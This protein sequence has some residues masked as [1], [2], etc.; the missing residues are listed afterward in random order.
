[1]ARHGAQH[2][3]RHQRV[4]VHA[5]SWLLLASGVVWLGVH[6]LVGAGAGE[7]PH[8]LEAWTLRTHALG[9]WLGAF[10]LGEIA[11]S[12]VPRGWH[13]TLRRHARAQRRLG[14]ALCT[15]GALLVLSGYALMYLVGE[16]TR[17]TWGWA[18]A[19]AGLAMAAVLVVHGTGV[20]S[21][22]AAT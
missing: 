19:I 14:I 18:H 1:M 20:L 10:T 11:A 8:P 15:L 4:L 3:S 2:L 12:H 9:A 17:P 6:Y 16:S 21:R 7:L 5:C 13:T 22:R